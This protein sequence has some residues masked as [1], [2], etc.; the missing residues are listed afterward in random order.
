[1]S[2]NKFIHKILLPKKENYYYPLSNDNLSKE[3]LN[4]GINVLK[5]G[6]ITMGDKTRIFEKN[7]A[8]K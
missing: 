7:F 3:D 6:K 1:M 2:K 4:A 8:K 5:S